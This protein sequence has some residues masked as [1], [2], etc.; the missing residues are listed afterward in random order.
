MQLVAATLVGLLVIGWGAMFLIAP[1][2]QPG[3]DTVAY[4]LPVA[5]DVEEEP[6]PININTADAKELM[7]LNGIG[8][9]R[10]AAILQY[11]QQYG[12]FADVRELE[13]VPGISSRMVER[14]AGQITVDDG[15]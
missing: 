7:L 6:W 11:R 15:P 14:W 3:Y 2:W 1:V 12:Q 8:E 4:T 10:A 5:A 9:A 13:N